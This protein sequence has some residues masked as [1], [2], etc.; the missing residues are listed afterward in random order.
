MAEPGYDDLLRTLL[1][2]SRTGI[3]LLAPIYRSDRTGQEV[4]DFTYER[5]NPAAQYLLGLPEYPSSSCR[6]LA[7]PHNAGF[8]FYHAAFLAESPT[9][10]SLVAHT[11]SG[12]PLRV[13]AQRHAQRL[14]VSFTETPPPRTAAPTTAAAEPGQATSRQPPAAGTATLPETRRPAWAPW[15]DQAP[16]AITVLS[17]PRYVVEL[18]NPAICALW[19][20]TREQ[21]LGQPLFE[22]LPEAA[23]HGLEDILAQVLATGQPYAAHELA[24][25]FM[26]DEAQ[27]PVYL[28]FVYQPLFEPD[29]RA[30]GVLVVMNDVSEQVGNRL[31]AQAL[32]AEL[33]LVN[34][35][36]RQLNQELECRVATGVRQAQ[37]A[38][39]EAERQQQR[40]TRFFQQAPAAI[41]V[42]DG[43]DLVYEL[44]NAG[45]QQFFPDRQ[46]LGRPLPEA[47]PELVQQPIYAWLRQVY[48]TGVPHEGHE[49][50]LPISG[51]AG[52]PPTEHYFNCVYQP[53]QDAHGRV[54]GVLVFALDV[55]DQVRAQQRVQALQAEAQL[56]VARRAQERETFYQVFEQ[57]P[58]AVAL[59]WGPEHRFEYVNRAY[60]QLFPG[61]PLRYRPLADALPDRVAQ[62]FAATLNHVYRTGETHFSNEV[63]LT[64]APPEGQAAETVYFSFAY[65][66]YRENGQIRGVS[67]FGYNVTAQVLARRQQEANAA[68]LYDQLRAV[69]EQ[70]PVA[71]ALLQGPEYVVAVA[72]PAIGALWGRDPAH[73]TNQPLFERL[74]EMAT[75][76]FRELLDTVRRTGEPYV[77]HEWPTQLLRHGRPET[78]YFNFVYQPLASAQGEVSS[79]VIVATDMT[80]AVQA[81]QQVDQV[82]DTLRAT[83]EQLTRTNV[84]LDNFIYTAS[85]DL[86]SPIANIEG[87]LLLLRQQLPPAA[88]QVGVVP[89]VLD[90][91]QGA[92][93]RFQLTI[94]QLTDLAKLQ[95]A[96]T[97]PAEEVDLP[98]V[99]EA[100]RLDMAPML[101]EAHA[102]LRVNLD[103]CRTVSFAPQHLRSIIYNLLSNAIKYR[104]PE[105]PLEIAIRCYNQDT[106]TLLEVQDNGLGLTPEQ[107][108]KLFGMFR[109]LHAHVP[110]SGVG[111][112]MVK[113]IL[114]NAGGSIA[115]Q[116]QSDIGTTFTVS[117]PG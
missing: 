5:L 55:T 53:R 109:R 9:Y 42:L 101:A 23:G 64:I 15:L 39:A 108:G 96:H 71:L 63:P 4:V 73:L 58:A 98:A 61:R 32:N 66:A 102:V 67:V 33:H 92:I 29:G 28:S 74:P 10:G 20:R 65:Q 34:E 43:P 17:G 3:A 86:R 110:G 88:Q 56:A 2:G 50:Q 69:F 111:L 27:Q 31:R 103:S 91:M 105:R 90:M 14:V 81:R 6:A 93:E 1:D 51:P 82:V 54:D 36:L 117:F 77:A 59:M 97:Q 48:E 21:V 7:P 99:V 76:G 94:A 45:Y 12:P 78:V 112:Y 44:V 114:E 16:V 89:R 46:L 41:C 40:L 85:H 22:V 106:A 60:A 70:A 30:T 24:S 25:R 72:N 8:A 83:N 115:V 19:Q 104:H 18:A 87:L 95:H 107:Q 11:A 116:S 37:A 49:V 113:R 84:D 75:Q 62:D 38:H 80:A 57:T 79:V 100:V 26:L 68:H 47:T 52:E 13:A 35:Q